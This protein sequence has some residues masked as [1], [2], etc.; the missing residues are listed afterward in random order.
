MSAKC[1]IDVSRRDRALSLPSEFVIREGRKAFVELPPVDPKA[2]D[3]KSERRPVT[4][5][6]QTGARVEILEGLKEGDK[7]QRPKFSGP[8]RQ[9]FMQAGP[10]E[11]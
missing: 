10:D 9:G 11:E 4:L 5:G 8:K 3:A 1:R 6:L 2:K 7:V